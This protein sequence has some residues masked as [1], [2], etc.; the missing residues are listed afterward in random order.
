MKPYEHLAISGGYAVC[1]SLFTRD[2]KIGLVSVLVGVLWDVDHFIDY[3]YR[4]GFNLDLR[5]FLTM[6]H[7]Q[8]FDK[9]FLFLHSYEIVFLLGI[10]FLYVKNSF[11][12]LGVFVPALLHLIC[13][14]IFNP[15][16]PLG[17]FLTL[18]VYHRFDT[19]FA[20]DREKFENE[21]H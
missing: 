15:V 3:W 6:C 8:Y 11:L 10:Y 17:Y 9:L 14:Q 19:D 13:D 1:I 20:F 2:W 4:F 12:F 7:A 18:R 21:K 5:K 16:K